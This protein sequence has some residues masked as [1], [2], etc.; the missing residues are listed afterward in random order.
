MNIKQ[1]TN[2]ENEKAIAKKTGI[3]FSDYGFP[4]SP[5]ICNLYK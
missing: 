1:H 3:L 2:K 5:T 4:T